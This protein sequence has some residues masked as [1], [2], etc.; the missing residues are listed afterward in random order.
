MPYLHERK[1]WLNMLTNNNQFY[2]IYRKSNDQLFIICLNMD[3]ERVMV[4]T[5]TG[6]LLARVYYSELAK[7]IGKPV[8]VSSN[9]RVVLFRKTIYSFELALTEVTIEEGIKLIKKINVK[10]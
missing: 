7:E 4:Y 6:I 1:I 8:K 9:G 2:T 5:E 10:E 3:E